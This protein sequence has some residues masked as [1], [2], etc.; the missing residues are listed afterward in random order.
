MEVSR[1]KKDG[2]ENFHLLWSPDPVSY[3]VDYKIPLI[4]K[5]SIVKWV[6]FLDLELLANVILSIL[7]L[8][9]AI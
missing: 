2:L 3:H 6:D 8:F 5:V 1:Q 4:F 9:S 7:A